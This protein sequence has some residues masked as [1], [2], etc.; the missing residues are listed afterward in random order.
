MKNQADVIA[1]M[2]RQIETEDEIIDIVER[3]KSYL[4]ESHSLCGDEFSRSS[5]ESLGRAI[6][7]M[8]ENSGK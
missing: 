5:A 2:L 7:V 3:I 8:K 1:E 6:K 4:D